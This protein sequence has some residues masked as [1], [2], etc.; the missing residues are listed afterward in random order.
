MSNLWTQF[1]HIED[2]DPLPTP[3]PLARR[4]YLEPLDSISFGHMN[5]LCIHCGVHHW[6]DERLK[7]G[8]VSSPCFSHCCHN[9]KV[10]ASVRTSGVSQGGRAQELS[11]IDNVFSVSM[12]TARWLC[13]YTYNR[14]C[15][16]LIISNQSWLRKRQPAHLSI[17]AYST[18]TEGATNYLSTLYTL[19]ARSPW[20]WYGTKGRRVA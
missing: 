3:L 5:I 19:R 7:N 18:M 20:L 14:Q 13:V 15:I 11:I 6:F 16:L 2:V 17:R 9:G 8:P 1:P 4:H 10:V 12:R